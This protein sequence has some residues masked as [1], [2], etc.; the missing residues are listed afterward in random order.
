MRVLICP[1][2]LFS[3]SLDCEG[4]PYQ[5][6]I[7]AVTH[8][9]HGVVC[10]QSVGKLRRVYNQKFPHRIRALER[11]LAVAL[12]VLEVVPAPAVDVSDEALVRDASDRP[13]LRAAIA[14]KADVL[15][16]GNRDFLESG[17]TDPKVV[18][19]TECLQME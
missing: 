8:P 4:T 3:A 18:T 14:A 2:I 12:T 10:D 15:V 11:F 17:I 19:A 6:Y 9:N 16:T 13:I 1:T 5:A 7:R